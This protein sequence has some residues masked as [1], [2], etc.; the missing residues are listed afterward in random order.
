MLF[1]QPVFAV[2]TYM[3][4]ANSYAFGLNLIQEL[5]PATPGGKAAFD[6]MIEGQS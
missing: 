4:P 5:G 6:L 2:S 3:E 1:S